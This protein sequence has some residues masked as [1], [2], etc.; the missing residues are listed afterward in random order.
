MSNTRFSTY[1]CFSFACCFCCSKAMPTKLNQEAVNDRPVIGILTQIVTDDVLKPFGRTFIPSSY[2]KFI[3]SGGGRVMPIR[4]TLNTA[5]YKKIFENI[6]GLLFIGGAADLETSDFA[7]VAKI[8]YSL[9][10]KA[11]NEGDFFPIWG[12]CM[13]M[14]LLTVLVAGENLLAN[15]TAENIALPLNLT[16][17]ASSSRMFEGFP[18]KLMRALTQEPLTGNFHHYGLTLE[19][20]QENEKLRSFFSL[21]STNVAENEVHFVSTI[22]GKRYP[23]YGVQWHPEVNR[24]QWNRKLNFPHSAHAVQLSSLLAE[25]FVNEGRRSLHQFDN[26]EEEASSLIYNNTPVYAGN[27]TGYEQLYFF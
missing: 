20:F 8:F 5:E 25:F 2:V 13:G 17:E 19:T 12:T 15:T 16:T 18:N 9:A 26:P 7:R 4:L 6:N 3:E 23:F 1:L 27:F 24:F 14:Q 10:L 21:L 11:N 22:E